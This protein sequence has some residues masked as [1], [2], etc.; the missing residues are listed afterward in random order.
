MIFLIKL[1]LEF[2]I[3]LVVKMV[4]FHIII[5]V[6]R[7]Q[8]CVNQSLAHDINYVKKYIYSSEHI[9]RKA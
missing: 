3:L 7:S 6:C 5:R 4:F 2:I 8:L 1:F 9:Y